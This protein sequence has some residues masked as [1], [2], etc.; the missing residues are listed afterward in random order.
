VFRKSHLRKKK[1]YFRK[2]EGGMGF[3]SQLQNVLAE[4]AIMKK[5]QHPNL[6]QL[7]EVIDY[8]EGDKL[9]ISKTL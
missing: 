5:L 9:Y 3:K 7:Y 8:D 2:P 1:E 4:I 6:I